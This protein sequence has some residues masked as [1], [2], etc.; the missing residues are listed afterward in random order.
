MTKA[1]DRTKLEK[2]IETALRNCGAD[3]QNGEHLFILAHLDKKAVENM[4][5]VQIGAIMS[6]IL[7][8]A[9]TAERLLIEQIEQQNKQWTD[10][11]GG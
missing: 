4:S 10:I 8:A 5:L 2:K 1:D 3:I 6:M 7:K 11:E 9:K